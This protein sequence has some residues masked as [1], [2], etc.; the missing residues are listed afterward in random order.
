[1]SSAS[2]EDTTLPMLVSE[3][4]RSWWRRL[5]LRMSV[6]TLMIVVFLLAGGLGWVVHLAHVQRDA[7]AAIR[8]GGGDTTYNW[9][10]KRSPD[11]HRRLN[12]KARPRAPKWLIDSLGPDF[13]GHVEL[14]RLGPRN[15]LEVMKHLGELDRLR[16]L[17]FFTGIDLTP[18]ASATLSSLPNTGLSRFKGFWNLATADQSPPQVDGANF[19]YLKH[20]T[21]LEY[22]NLPGNVSVTDDDLANFRK[23]NSLRRLELRDPRV[24]DLGLA[25]LKEMTKLEYLELESTQVTGAGLRS[26]RAMTALSHLNLGQTRVD[27]LSQIG[28]LKSLTW[29]DLSHTPID[30]NALAS[31]ADL[32]GLT[33]LHLNGTKITGTGFANHKQLSKLKSVSLRDTRIRDAGLAGLAEV[34]ALTRLSLDNTRI[35]DA[36]LV[37]LSCSRSLATVSL[38]STEITDGGLATMANCETI[39]RL[40]VRRTKVTRAGVKAFRDRR[41][42][43]RVIW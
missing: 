3:R 41:P 40:N 36:G 17:T 20:M 23:L 43:V 8:S 10:L 11:G 33:D 39:V 1:M 12:P 15:Q 13:F 2:T 35:T 24:T 27:D 32:I 18:L 9:Q 37:Y 25:A 28:H 34:P 31:I 4:P 19:K 14:V 29:L 21:R 6:R 26:L 22:L 7:I 16:G 42:N 5:P 30:D 38:S